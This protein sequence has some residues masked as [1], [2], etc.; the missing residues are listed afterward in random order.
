MIHTLIATAGVSVFSGR[1]LGRTWSVTHAEGLL[2]FEDRSP[3]PQLTPGVEVE[4]VLERWRSTRPTVEDER[5]ISAEYSALHAL[6]LADGARVVL[7]HSDT[8]AGALAAHLVADLIAERTTC[9]V[10]LISI[11]DLDPD[12]P[13]GV[14]A[15]IADFVRKLSD[16]LIQGEPRTTAFAPIGGFKVMTALG[17]LVGAYHGYPSVYLH[18][19]KQLVHRVPPVRI[20][21]DEDEL[22]PVADLVRRARTGVEVTD[23]AEQRAI[24]D[25]PWLFERDGDIVYLNAFGELLRVDER[26]LPILGARVWIAERRAIRDHE[27]MF[28]REVRDLLKELARPHEH[29]GTLSHGESF[30][31]HGTAFKVYRGA[32][33]GTVTF[34]AAYAY[35]EAKERLDIRKVWFDHDRYERDVDKGVGLGAYDGSWTDVSDVVWPGKA[36]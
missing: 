2:T 20:R 16:A 17:Y 1:N 36:S 3:V 27:A 26:Y 28:R 34:T 19:G 7:L 10:Q 29:R 35:D 25:L 12:R 8:V 13:R 15:A 4:Q 14:R 5:R 33:N 21:V 11:T 18:E 9:H 30:Q 23:A 31:H 6:D 32:R 24:D 22:R